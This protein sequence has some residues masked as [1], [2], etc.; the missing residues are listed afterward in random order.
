M[1]CDDLNSNSIWDEP[2]PTFYMHRKL[3]RPYHI[4]YAFV[5]SDLIS[6]AEVQFGGAEDWLLYSDHMP[7][8]VDILES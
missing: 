6:G 4:D 3:D 2:D 8:V 5:S 7:V 1:L